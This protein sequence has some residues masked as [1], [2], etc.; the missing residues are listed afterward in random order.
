MADSTM[1]LKKP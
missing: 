1:E